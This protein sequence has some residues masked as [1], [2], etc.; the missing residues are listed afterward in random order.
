MAA[1]HQP[2]FVSIPSD[3]A[4]GLAADPKKHLAY[5]NTAHLYQ[6]RPSHCFQVHEAERTLSVCPRL[7]RSRAGPRPVH[8]FSRMGVV[9]SV[10]AQS[11]NGVLTYHPVRLSVFNSPSRRYRR[12]WIKVLPYRQVIAAVLKHLLNILEDAY[13]ELCLLKKSFPGCFEARLCTCEMTT[14]PIH[15]LTEQQ[16]AGLSPWTIAVNLLLYYAIW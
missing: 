11:D 7:V 1:I 8:G 13:I 2:V 16:N 10:R 12:F 4:N 15:T 6:R 14:L 5:T 3:C 9:C